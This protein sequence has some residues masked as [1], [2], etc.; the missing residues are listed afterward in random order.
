M[1]KVYK[2]N[3]LSEN[4]KKKAAEAVHEQEMNKEQDWT[5]ECQHITEN[6][7]Y[8]IKEEIKLDCD[9]ISWEERYGISLDLSSVSITQ[10]YLKKIL[11]TEEYKLIGE[12][13]ELTDN[14]TEHKLFDNNHNKD[15]YVLFFDYIEFDEAEAMEFI[16]KHSED[17]EIKAKYKFPLLL[18]ITLSSEE[19]SELENEVAEIGGRLATNLSEKVN[20]HIS[21]LVDRLKEIVKDGCDYL[22][23]EEYYYEQMNAD[24]YPVDNYLF[25]Y[26]GELILRDGEY[27]D[28]N[29]KEIYHDCE[30]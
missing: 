19:Y 21:D 15:G 22:G 4:A 20:S 7:K 13:E 16:M 24:C 26:Q 10:E 28:S 6:L 3:N 11:S 1:K 12:L 25:S 23:S 9:D 17:E 29:F 27:V 30:V 14:Y 8:I 5:V 2:F 18:E